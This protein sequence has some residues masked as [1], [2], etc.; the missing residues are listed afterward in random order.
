M[1]ETIKPCVYRGDKIN[2]DLY[3]CFCPKLILM[4]DG[5]NTKLCNNCNLRSENPKDIPKRTT[6]N[7][8]ADILPIVTTTKLKHRGL[9][10]TT[11]WLIRKITFG[12]LKKKKGC[13][14]NSRQQKLN[15]L[16]P[17]RHGKLKGLISGVK[18]LTVS[19]KNK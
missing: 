10:D 11:E 13:G 9:G 12:K 5:V 2:S 7:T 8:Q 18:T 17:Y 14:C 19:R 6:K 1:T 3:Q 16:F 15:K 4:G